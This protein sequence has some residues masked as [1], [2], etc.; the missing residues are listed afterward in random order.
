MN[1]AKP[2]GREAG[3]EIARRACRSGYTLVM[4][5]DEN[6]TRGIADYFG[7][8]VER[9]EECVGPLGVDVRE[10]ENLSRQRAA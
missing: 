2:Q 10:L 8:S 4:P 1:P 7:V 6:E 9:V 5:R 3:R